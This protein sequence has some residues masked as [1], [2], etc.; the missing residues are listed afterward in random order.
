MKQESLPDLETLWVV[1]YSVKDGN[2]HVETL[3]DNFK[4]NRR[5]VRASRSTDYVP[6]FVTTSHEKANKITAQLRVEL[7]KNV[8][9]SAS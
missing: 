8:K 7:A 4:A 6:I 2:S 9:R 1:V 3:L 5:A